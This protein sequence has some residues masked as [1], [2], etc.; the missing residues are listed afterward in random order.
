MAEDPMRADMVALMAR[1]MQTEQALL[2][3]RLVSAGPNTAPLVVTRTVGAAPTFTGE[4]KDWPEWSFQFTASTGSANSSEKTRPQAAFERTH[5]TVEETSQTCVA[6]D[7]VSLPSL[8]SERWTTHEPCS[9][10]QTSRH[11]APGNPCQQRPSSTDGNMKSRLPVFRRRAAMTRAVLPTTS[12]KGQWFL[13][14]LIDR[15]TSHWIRG[16]RRRR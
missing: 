9:T 5:P 6:R 8:D 11:A 16:S 2:D 13:T 15:A 12:A 1:V 4:R 10:Q 14:R 3:T 7:P